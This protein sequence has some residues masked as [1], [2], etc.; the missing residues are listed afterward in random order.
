MFAEYAEYLPNHLRIKKNAH[1]EYLKTN[2]NKRIAK[3]SKRI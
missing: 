1:K 2:G 3:F